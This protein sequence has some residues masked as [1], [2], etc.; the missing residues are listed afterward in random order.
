MGELL[1]LNGDFMPIREG[2]VSCEDRGFNFADGVYEVVRVYGGQPFT[3]REHL[4][5]QVQSAQGLGFEIPLTVEEFGEVLRELI[6]RSGYQEALLYTQVTR[7]AAPR[8]HLYENDIRPTVMAFIRPPPA[9]PREWREVGTM[10]LPQ[11]DI[12][13]DLCNLKTISLLAN[14]LAKNRA[15]R[16]GGVEALY[17]LPD[18]TVTEGSAT[19]A[20]A[21][22]G[23]EVWTAPL[24]PKILPGIT[25]RQIL[26]MAETLGVR[27]HEKAL[28]LGEFESADEVF[29]SASN[30]ELL[31]VTRLD[32][33]VI[34]AGKPGPVSLRLHE[35]YRER[36]RQACGIAELVPL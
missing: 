19:N 11:P 6:D 23:G 27:V 18:G 36:V 33:R 17:H 25:R 5:R 12:R 24:G 28:T 20:Y 29:L 7:G 3:A 13:W 8:Q 21:V 30:L 2:R 1:Y 34:G 26:A 15:H 9:Q 14:I 31:P 32:Q 16:A 10:A 35:A 22:R 4:E